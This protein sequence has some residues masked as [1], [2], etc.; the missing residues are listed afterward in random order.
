[1]CLNLYLIYNIIK[2]NC[3]SNETECW[4]NWLILTLA[5]NIT[6]NIIFYI[7]YIIAFAYITDTFAPNTEQ[8]H[9]F[10]M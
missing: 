10:W 7:F 5:Y 1:M 8:N 6:Y 9:N 4:N 3:K 2:E